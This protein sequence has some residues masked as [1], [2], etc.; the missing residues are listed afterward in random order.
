MKIQSKNK[1]VTFGNPIS[2]G[3]QTFKKILGVV[4]VLFS[5]Y[6]SISLMTI[7]LK[8]IKGEIALTE[9]VFIK[10]LIPDSPE[11]HSLK[12]S[13]PSEQNNSTVSS[14]IEIPEQLLLLL[15]ILITIFIVGFILRIVLAILN[16]G[17]ALMRDD[18]SYVFEKLRKEIEHHRIKQ[19]EQE[20]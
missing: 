17:I 14:T 1:N 15:A 18:V 11:K 9:N 13:I 10:S 5:L 8:V 4:L 16:A 2:G 19:P 12:F 7:G 3:F 20:S 6:A